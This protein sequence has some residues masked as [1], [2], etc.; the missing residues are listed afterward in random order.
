MGLVEIEIS[1][2]ELDELLSKHYGME[3]GV[4]KICKYNNKADYVETME[5]NAGDEIKIIIKGFVR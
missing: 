5:F 2:N 3:V 4:S 1:G